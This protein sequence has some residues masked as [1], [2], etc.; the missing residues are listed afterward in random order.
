M[1]TAHFV[2]A[3]DIN[4]QSINHLLAGVMPLAAD[5]NIDTL[6]MLIASNGGDVQ[7]ALH[8]YNLIRAIPKMVTTHNVGNV[9]S[10]ANVLF[11]AGATRY[12]AADSKFMFHGVS[13]NVTTAPQSFNREQLANM[14]QALD[15]LNALM[16]AVVAD[17][18]TIAP[19]AVADLYRQEQIKTPD[20][21]LADGIIH[22]IR[23]ADLNGATSVA[24]ING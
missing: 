16:V 23:P 4:S 14:E 21:A 22:E 9:D 15:N 12:A 10:A 2:F 17:R 11:L 18:T 13:F 5:P 1:S 19:A 3:C 24:Y 7:C 6:Y 20:Q 8:A